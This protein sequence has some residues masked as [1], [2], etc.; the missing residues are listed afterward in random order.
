[1][2]TRLLHVC[3]LDLGPETD[4]MPARPDNPDGFWENLRFVSLNDELLG[5]LGGAWD[6]PPRRDEDFGDPR[7]EPLRVKARL[8]VAG[9]DRAS[10]WGWK[11]P[12][13]SLTLPF[14]KTILPGLKTVVLVRNPLE[15]AH[16]M[17]ERNGT[18][19]SFG[20]R[21]WEIYNRRIIETTT[22]EERLL[23]QYDFFFEKSESE[24]RRIADFIGLSH[25]EVSRAATLVAT[26][27]RHTHFTMDQLVDAQVSAEVIDFY[28]QLLDEAEHN[29]LRGDLPP[30][31]FE[32]EGAEVKP[33]VT[34]HTVRSGDED[35]LP[36]TISR[37][38][39]SIPERE[40]KLAELTSHLARQDDRIQEMDATI[41]RLDTEIENIRERF[42]QT[43]QL[44]HGKSIS[45]AE[46]EARSA[47][48]M[49]HL[50][51][52]L[53]ATK[54]LV[55]LL[56]DADRAAERL[57]QSR[58]WKIS[59][60]FAWLGSKFSGN[61]F[62]G[63]GHL[64]KVV[65]NFRQWR[66]THPEVEDIDATIQALK[67]QGMGSAP[68]RSKLD[69]GLM[70]KL[71]H[72]IE[73][74]APLK[75]I[76]FPV[77]EHVKVSVIIPV[78]NNFHFTQA[79]LASVQENHDYVPFE[80][81]VIDDC[82]IDA[83]AEMIQKIPGIT[84]LR[85]ERNA[86][87]IASC[88]YGA[89]K[90]RGS[91]LFFLNNDTVVT[92]GWLTTLCET[93]E[94]EPLAG[95][96]GSK[97]VFPDGRLQEAGGI[98]WRDASGWNRG[99]FQ[100]AEKPEFSFLREV[101]YCSA[102]SLM[103]PKSLFE[104]LGG[105]DS[106]YA[107]GY[108]EDTDLAF[109]VRD[110]GHKVL[111]QPL[112]KVIHYEGATGGTDTSFGAKKYQEINRVTFAA[113]WSEV[114]AGKPTNGD[115]VAHEAL[116]PE[117]KRIL[118]IDHH[119][120]MPDRDSGSLRMFQM[121]RILH[122]LGHRVTFLPDNLAD[123][124]P[125]G[126]DLRKRGIEVVHHP[127]VKSVREYLE[128]RELQFDV[129][130]LSRC[131][132][133][134]KHIADVRQC[135]PQSRIIFDT[136][137]LHF[138]REER[139]AEF[140]QDPALKSKAAERRGLEYDLIDRADETWVVSPTERELLHAERPDKSIQVVSNI[141]ETPGS[142]T[143]FS[144]RREI[145]F[146]GSFQH[147]P[148]IDA[149]IFFCHEIFPLV[150]KELDAKFYIIGDKAP[151]ELI[152][153]ADEDIVLAGFQRDV[154]SF[155][156]H[157]RLSVAPL[158]FGAGVKGK[159]NQSMGYGVPVVA[160]SLAV[161]GMSLKANDDVMIADD[162]AAFATAVVELYESEQLWTRLSSN[163]LKQ[164]EHLFSIDTARRQLARILNNEGGEL[165][166]LHVASPESLVGASAGADSRRA[167]VTP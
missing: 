65:D 158:R 16:S 40:A 152:A 118:V 98:I 32:S 7:L 106:K 81:I 52:Q 139:E 125:Y 149:V 120:P 71:T 35:L 162:P 20:L 63:F 130:I 66:S 121:L 161:E 84:Y 116:K 132:F 79:C 91:Y 122:G 86:G 141:V 156:N 82:S 77:H 2:L 48:L 74:P 142:A 31:R 11:D 147:T 124:P 110:A 145:L 37:V 47:T 55:H 99:K 61:L 25:S 44:L 53:R 70:R 6:L 104:R 51:K 134:S 159:I 143:P 3:G 160:T 57:R 17:R 78:F 131:D 150:R 64:D 72:S 39:A 5:E 62:P 1:M 80:V 103:I 58:R 138:L 94:F 100:D 144:L 148:N 36:G 137:D 46:E 60:P 112:S 54:R 113:S 119:L 33:H 154:S 12:R 101:D 136:V 128:D 9:F 105:F 129:V 29:F 83:T 13:N 135:A 4:L 59:N 151:P 27:R 90:A 123:I 50:G 117:Q 165:S 155:F 126:D 85:N 18:S 111:Y 89:R 23:T 41:V 140:M 133:A 45:L 87:F 73:P 34:T 167:V 22:A 157:V 97:L 19:Y 21:L 42:I 69:A 26:G 127:Y 163:G 75:P 92:P 109:K 15:V 88:N 14:W 30:G 68:V 107:P 95:L 67:P 24:L 114:L 146:I 115:I 56:Q 8:L 164:T 96:V 102:A 108:Y 43:N 153:L 10:A 28:R 93:F 76:E 38:R 49:E 166:A